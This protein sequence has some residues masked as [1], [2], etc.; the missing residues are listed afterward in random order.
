[1]PA[2]DIF[3]VKPTFG[4]AFSADEATLTFTLDDGK[5]GGLG[6]L[7]QGLNAR[8]I[9]PVQRIFELGPQKQ[10]YYV[11][12]RSE[13]TMNIQRLA[14][15]G[16]ISTKFIFKYANPC[17][18][19]DNHITITVDPGVHSQFTAGGIERNCPPPGTQASRWHFDF[20]LITSLAVA[21]TVQTITLQETIDLMF[22]SM[23]LEEA[24]RAITL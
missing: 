5:D 10:T 9:R 8:Y 16:P 24:N 4:G 7:V 11:V 14:A 19:T 22:A 6:L 18:V 21:I 2:Q 1:M 12:G 20:C 3:G 23:S 17:R 13:G 15:P